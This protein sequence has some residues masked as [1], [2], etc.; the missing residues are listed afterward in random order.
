MRS[1]NFFI[2]YGKGAMQLSEWQEAALQQSQ[3]ISE[4]LEFANAFGLKPLVAVKFLRRGWHFFPISSL[5]KI[6]KEF[7]ADIS[8]GQGFENLS[9]I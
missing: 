1:A 6:E 8:K 3:Q 7:V 5:E 4:L 2:Y 9:I